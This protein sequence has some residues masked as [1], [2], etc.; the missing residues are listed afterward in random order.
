MLVWRVMTLVCAT[1]MSVGAA[2]GQS[3]PSASMQAVPAGASADPI[4]TQPYIDK[5]EIRE[6]PVYHRYVHG[7]FKDTGLRFS[8]YFPTKEQYQGHFFQYLTPVPDSETLSQ[9]QE[10]ENDKIGFSVSHGAYFIETYGGGS[11]ATAGPAFTTDPSIGG[12]RANAAAAQF[13]RVVAM[14]MYASKR[15]FGYIFG[16]RGGA[17][18]TVGE[19]VGV[20]DGA[21]PFVMGSPMASPYNCCLVHLR[22]ARTGENAD[23]CMA[24][25]H[26]D[27]VDRTAQRQHAVL[28]AQQHDPFARHILGNCRTSSLV[29]AR[30]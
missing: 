10:G 28:V 26:R 3:S 7:G 25:D 22:T 15:P 12:Y 11:S 23:V 18:R 13:S 2:L 17:Y 4:F 24:A 6:L 20:W 19:T 16:G 30:A 9:G 5:D 21:V 1:M 27:P 14:D 29:N 8:F